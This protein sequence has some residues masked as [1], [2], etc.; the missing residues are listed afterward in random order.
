[1]EVRRVPTF[2]MQGIEYKINDCESYGNYWYTGKEYK[3]LLLSTSEP[4][5]DKGASANPTKSLCNPYVFNTAITR[6]QSLV[7]CVG[8]PFV[9][10]KMEENMIKRPGYEEIGK[11]WSN[12][13]KCCLENG[14]MDAAESLGLSEEQKEG[15]FMK[16]KDLAENCLKE[17]IQYPVR[18]HCALSANI[19]KLIMGKDCM[20]G[21]VKL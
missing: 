3:V 12:Y 20:A 11:C 8:N 10:L 14:S 15:L 17:K 21:S 2:F 1:M 9:L 16:I 7:V 13:F 18:E 19:T 4:M 5:T 6:A